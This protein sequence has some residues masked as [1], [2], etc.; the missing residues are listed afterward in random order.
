MIHERIELS[1]GVVV[2]FIQGDEGMV[3]AF[4]ISH[5]TKPV[6]EIIMTN[7]KRVALF[8]DPQDF[9][10]L[11]QLF[12]KLIPPVSVIDRIQNFLLGRKS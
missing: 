2:S 12:D 6:S 4:H 11:K 5:P 8:V 1:C 3:G 9:P 10:K 7:D